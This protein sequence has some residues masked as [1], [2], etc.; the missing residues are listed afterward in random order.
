MIEAQNAEVQAI[1]L[2]VSCRKSVILL[3]ANHDIALYDR[4][5]AR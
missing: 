2:S 4:A 5:S 1:K 3:T